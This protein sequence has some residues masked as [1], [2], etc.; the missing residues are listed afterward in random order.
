M[1]GSQ[2]EAARIRAEAQRQAEEI[3]ASQK[4]QLTEAVAVQV[5]TTL[6]EAQSKAQQTR[7]KAADYLERLHARQQL[8]LEG[9]AP[10]C[11]GLILPPA[12]AATG[13]SKVPERHR[14]CP[15]YGAP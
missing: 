10:E 4:A 5:Q 8:G 14:L 1:A 15:D 9:V 13:P 6:A 3:A 12:D 11:R 2:V 7:T